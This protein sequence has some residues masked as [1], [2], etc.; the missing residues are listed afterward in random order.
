VTDDS[1]LGGYVEVHDRPPAFEGSDGC[2]YSAGVFV[3][4][5]AD[6]KG[7]FG[8]AVLFVRWSAEGE[9]PVGHLETPYLA[10]GKT[11]DEADTAIRQLTLHEIKRQLD[12]AIGEQKERPVW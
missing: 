1:T 5:S 7:R 8:A 6:D 3:D 10:F 2:A 12:R 4:D 11:P 9:H